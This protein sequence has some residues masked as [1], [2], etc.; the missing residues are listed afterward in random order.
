MAKKN[1]KSGDIVVAYRPAYFSFVKCVKTTLLLCQLEYWQYKKDGWFWKTHDELTQEIGLT[2]NE[3]D[4]AR[5]RLLE[6]SLIQH[7][8]RGLPG[9]SH[10]QVLLP[11]LYAAWSVAVKMPVS[12]H[13]HFSDG[14]KLSIYKQHNSLLESSKHL[15][16][17]ISAEI[18]KEISSSSSLESEKQKAPGQIKSLDSPEQK[19]APTPKPDIALEEEV[20]ACLA[21]FL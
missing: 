7:Q 12:S 1:A 3:L 14:R 8:V 11:N 6:Q 9:R 5:G 13:P 21:E 2:R 15:I 4:R 19:S 18:S 10:Y 16:S 17:K 20:A